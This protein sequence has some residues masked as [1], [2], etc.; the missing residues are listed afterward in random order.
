MSKLTVEEMIERIEMFKKV[1]RKRKGK[2]NE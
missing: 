1:F 2:R